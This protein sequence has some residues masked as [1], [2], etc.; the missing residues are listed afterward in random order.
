MINELY[1]VYQGLNDVGE[2]PEIKHNDI[3]SPGKGTT[4]RISLSKEGNIDNIEL[5]TKEK[6]K[7]I[8]SIRDGQQNQFPAAKF[9]YPFIPDGNKDYAEWRKNSKNSDATAYRD[10]I[11]NLL[12]QYSVTI[13]KI[14]SWP[15]YR[16]RIL[17][18]KEQLKEPLLRNQE[19]SY[20]YDLFERYSKA[21]NNGLSIL[22]QFAEKLKSLVNIID[23]KEK[24]KIIANTFF[25][26]SINAK[27]KIKDGNRVTLLID[28]MPQKDI[29][30][31]ASS[32]RRISI[33]SKALYEAE[34]GKQIKRA[35]CALTNSE[36][37]V[38]SGSFPSENLNV[39]GQTFLLAKSDTTSGPT[40][41]RYGKAG[42]DSFSLNRL[43]GEKLA[44]SITFLTKDS[45]EGKTWK[46][47]P[48][49]TGSS[50]SLLIGYC[51]SNFDLTIT[52]IITGG[53]ID[54][55]DDY[56]NATKTVLDLFNKSNCT[57]DDVVEIAEIKVLD[58][59]NR[60]INYA[61]SATIE[62]LRKAANEWIKAC[63]NCPDFKLFAKIKATSKLL[64]PW[65]IAPIE[66][67][68]LTQNKYIRD[69]L[70]STSVIPM[71]FTDTMTLFISQSD[72]VKPAALRN[73]Q[74][75]ANQI[76]PLFR[77]C[78][79]SKNQW[80][81]SKN[82]QQVVTKS[83]KNSLALRVA[84]LFAVL[85]YKAGR[86][87][88]EY[89]DSFAYQLGQLCSAMDELHIGYCQD[90]RK[91]DIPNTLIG[92]ATY[93]IAL[94]SPIKALAFLASRIKPY[95]VWAKKK[96]AE[97]KEITDKAIIAGLSASVWLESHSSNIEKHLSDNSQLVNDTYKTELMLGY[98]AGR[99]FG[100][101]EKE[102]NAEGV[103]K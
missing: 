86:K 15:S 85:L 31:Y 59:A 49:S 34:H 73:L 1:S 66:A 6:I 33:L 65:A 39:V 100:K 93:N 13:P 24:L 14:K 47:I 77:Y 87:K 26:D 63:N 60:K 91:G 52:P 40:V 17:E 89:M 71:S 42:T 51:K 69:G 67:T 8:W 21:G 48:S 82:N 12:N 37:E 32:K 25:G 41:R 28:C 10:M 20:I 70:S 7:D 90:M 43:I 35:I 98:L 58:K 74:K 68:Y 81:L 57:P 29:D 23:N 88:E 95:K 92:N 11:N 19:G 22:Y 44:A 36:G 54:D 78:A 27:G 97:N 50:A 3:V 18:R 101:M 80:P 76:E 9:E 45:L 53:D 46:K 2:E 75:L 16:K 4:F 84:T 55:F 99:P 64:S 72:S 79:L 38:I 102:N 5:L 96:R 103:E 94:Q 83:D 62:T 61:T 30:V 56:Q